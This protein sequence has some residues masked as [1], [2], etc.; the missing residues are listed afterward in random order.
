MR[1]LVSVDLKAVAL[2]VQKVSVMTGF[3][4]SHLSGGKWRFAV[5]GAGSKVFDY[6]IG[7]DGKL[8]SV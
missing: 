8:G 3:I 2:Q 5:G 1:S 7:K 4:C 6:S